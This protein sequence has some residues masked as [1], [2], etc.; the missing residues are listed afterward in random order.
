MWLY[1]TCYCFFFHVRRQKFNRKKK[2][3]QSV[4]DGRDLNK[5]TIS[6]SVQRITS[7]RMTN[8]R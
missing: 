8:E 7:E 4:Q 5:I 6:Q 2:E 3:L 1:V